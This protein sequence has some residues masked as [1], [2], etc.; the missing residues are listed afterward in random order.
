[1]E[2]CRAGL[3]TYP[4]FHS[5]RVTLARALTELNL[6]D[7]AAREL[8]VVLEKAPRHPAATRAMVL[9]QRR[10]RDGPESPPPQ[11]PANA[12]SG[13]AAASLRDEPRMTAEPHAQPRPVRTM[14]DAEYVRAVRVLSA[15]ESW[16]TAIN[17]TRAQRRA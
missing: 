1:V 7:E 15:L 11:P 10:L 5:A 13:A 8:G 6:L 16:L 12:E 3:L 14:D 9:I 2:I 4:A 17:V